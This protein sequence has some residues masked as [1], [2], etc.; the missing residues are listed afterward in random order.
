M[1]SHIIEPRNDCKYFIVGKP[2]IVIFELND[3]TIKKIDNQIIVEIKPPKS[4]PSLYT[5]A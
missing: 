1:K 5:E 2:L 3:N 4:P